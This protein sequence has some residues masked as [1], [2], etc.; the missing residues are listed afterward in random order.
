MGAWRESQQ[1]SQQFDKAQC[2]NKQHMTKVWIWISC[3]MALVGIHNHWG[4][5]DFIIFES[6]ISGCQVSLRTKS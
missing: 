2:I 6:K 1:G 5:F 4:T 3:H